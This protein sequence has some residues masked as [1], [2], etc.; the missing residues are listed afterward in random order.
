MAARGVTYKILLGVI[1]EVQQALRD[2]L[3]VLLPL[4]RAED[5][6]REVPH[7][8]NDRDVGQLLLGQDF[9]ALKQRWGPR[10]IRGDVTRKRAAD[11][12][13]GGLAGWFQSTRKQEA[14]DPGASAPVNQRPR[15]CEVCTAGRR[16]EG[17]RGGWV[18]I[19]AA[20]G[21]MRDI[22]GSRGCSGHFPSWF[23]SF[24]TKLSLALAQSS[25]TLDPTSK[26]DIILLHRLANGV[27]KVLCVVAL[28]NGGAWL[29]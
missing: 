28:Q 22:E 19:G 11:M 18:G 9:G 10:V 1:P 25:A 13:S 3:A 20:L 23:C 17:L 8:A 12:L 6:L 24:N 16:G 29:S 21:T 14:T 2:G 15:L 7:P 4:A 27:W 26:A 5:H